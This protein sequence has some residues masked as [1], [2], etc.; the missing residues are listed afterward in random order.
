MSEVELFGGAITIDY[1]AG[2]IDA[3]DLRQIPDTQEVY[4]SRNSDV[5]Y[6]V[7]ILEKVEANDPKEAAIFHFESLAHDNNAVSKTISSVTDHSGGDFSAGPE[8]T[9]LPVVLVGTQQ[10]PKYNR[11][12]PDTVE[13]F[14]AL[15][16]VVEKN[17]DI[18]FTM[19]IPVV[20]NEG[21]GDVGSI[22]VEAAKPIFE[23]A[24]RSF[25]IVDFG[26]FV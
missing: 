26:L 21:D 25:K 18:V 3:S 6:I 4:L 20:T 16:R 10:V 2:L 9:P 12:V 22:G 23:R 13:I 11:T 8:G 1:P 19:N 14:M 17:T 7:E 15:Y 5:S 24:V